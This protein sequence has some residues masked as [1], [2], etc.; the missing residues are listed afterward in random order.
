MSIQIRFTITIMSAMVQEE[1]V[2]TSKRVKFGKEQNAK[3]DRVP[4][5]VYGY[6]KIPG[7][8]F[9]LI[10]NEEEACTLRRIFRLYA[11][12][13]KGCLS[14]ANCLNRE[15]IRT[16]RGCEWSQNAVSRILK[17][18]IYIGQVINGKEETK[19]IYSS[20]RL[21]KSEEA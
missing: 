4:N 17:N 7:G 5:L 8:Y 20:K 1:S 13:G 3:K 15:E 18:E 16:K 10:I 19:E 9:R 2:N 11:E 12:E 6:D 21:K 14:I